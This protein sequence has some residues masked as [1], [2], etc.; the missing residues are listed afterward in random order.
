LFPPREK[1][2]NTFLSSG[3]IHCPDSIMGGESEL[4]ATQK[5]RKMEK[6]FLMVKGCGK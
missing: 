6:K 2:T 4:K 1:E 5:K 3:F